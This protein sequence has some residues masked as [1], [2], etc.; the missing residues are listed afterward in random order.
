MSNLAR[1]VVGTYSIVHDRVPV[2][3]SQDLENGEQCVQKIV[4]ISANITSTFNRVETTTEQLHAQQT[5]KRLNRVHN[6][7]KFKL[8]PED[9]N[10]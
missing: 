10:K 8:L 9:D 2:F 4:E 1:S 5:R 6:S 3:T 7:F